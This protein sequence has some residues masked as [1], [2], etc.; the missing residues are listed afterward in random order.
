M[1]MSAPGFG[2]HFQDIIQGERG[3]ESWKGDKCWE[4]YVSPSSVSYTADL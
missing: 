4:L 3:K 2:L 1:D